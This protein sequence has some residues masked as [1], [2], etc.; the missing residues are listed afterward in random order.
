MHMPDS[1]VLLVAIPAGVA[2]VWFLSKGWRWSAWLTIFAWICWCF[3][4][5]QQ[6]IVR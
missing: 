5:R 3:C 2:F 6:G 4:W 1:A